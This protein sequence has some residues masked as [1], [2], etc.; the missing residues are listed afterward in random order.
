MSTKVSRVGGMNCGERK[1]TGKKACGEDG[2]GRDWEDAWRK[3]QKKEKLT[4]IGGRVNQGFRRK[5]GS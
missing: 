2:I 5:K 3:H 1:E 4:N